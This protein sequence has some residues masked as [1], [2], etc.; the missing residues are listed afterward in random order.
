M[1]YYIDQVFVEIVRFA[2]TQSFSLFG[3]GILSSLL[4]ILFPD[5]PYII[6]SCHYISMFI[7]YHMWML[8]C[9]IAVIVIHFIRF[10]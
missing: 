2:M 6:T 1:F 5:S 9:D 8:I 10:I 7:Y 4:F 3:S